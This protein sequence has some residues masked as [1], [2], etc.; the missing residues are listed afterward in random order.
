MSLVGKGIL[1]PFALDLSLQ[2]LVTTYWVHLDVC[3]LGSFQHVFLKQ[4]KQY[5]FIFLR[6]KPEWRNWELATNFRKFLTV[7]AQVFLSHSG[8]GQASMMIVVVLCAIYF[9]VTCNDDGSRGI[10]EGTTLIAL[11]KRGPYRRESSNA[12]EFRL[13]MLTRVDG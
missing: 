7:A 2:H 12:L 6:Y 8:T 3:C 13:L 5:G 10:P 1:H 4:R 9:Q 11:E